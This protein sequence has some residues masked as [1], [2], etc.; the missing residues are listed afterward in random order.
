MKVHHGDVVQEDELTSLP[1]N[2]KASTRYS[3]QKC[4][5]LL[6]LTKK[7]MSE[8]NNRKINVIHS[9]EEVRSSI[10]HNDVLGVVHT[11]L[12]GDTLSK[13]ATHIN[14]VL[15]PN[16]SNVQ[17]F[18]DL[19]P[20]NLRN[21]I[22]KVIFK[23]KEA[24]LKLHMSKADMITRLF[25]SK[26][27]KCVFFINVVDLIWSLIVN[28]WYTILINGQNGTIIFASSDKK[29]LELIRK[30][31]H[32]YEKMFDQLINKGRKTICMYLIKL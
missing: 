10:V 19:R 5:I 28:Y 18:F 23:D 13:S 25:L 11:F 22:N 4:V 3:N 8:D 17:T 9:L 1:P 30:V 2:D 29:S 6:G 7:E 15:L 14:L 32:D 31:L 26:V 24:F 12:R 21:F 27:L 20:I 16:K